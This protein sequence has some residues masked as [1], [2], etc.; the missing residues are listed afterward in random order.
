MAPSSLPF[1]LSFS[2]L[3]CPAWTLRQ[4]ME[5]A[6]A[7]GYQGVDFRGIGDEIDITKLPAFNAEIDATLS[8]FREFNLAMPCLNTSVTLV[9]PSPQ[10]WQEMLDECHRYALLAEKTGTTMLRVFG[11]AVP[12]ELSRGEA[13]TLARR[14]LR[15]LINMCRSSGCRPVLETHDAWIRVADVMELLREYSPDEVG[16]LWDTEHTY[17][18]GEAPVET[19]SGLKRFIQ[20]THFK[21]SLHIDGKNSPRLMGEGDLPIA[22]CLDALQSMDYA[23]YCSLAT[24]KRWHSAAP[25]AEVSVPQFAQYMRALSVDLKR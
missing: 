9:S 6:A 13:V 22:A 2:T 14:H 19:V 23:G 11:G 17:R 3:A 20:H 1:R 10:R 18:A 24:E 12:T 4:I 21:D 7:D 16:V 15:Q 5:N 8:F 25:E